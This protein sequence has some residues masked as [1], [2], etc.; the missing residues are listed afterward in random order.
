VEPASTAGTWAK[1]AEGVKDWPLWLF[2][3][4]ALSLSVF[5]AVPDFRG[6]VSPSTCTAVLFATTVAWILA[7]TRS[8]TP[9][10]LAWRTW[11][12]SSEARTR[13]VVTPI[14]HQC[15]WGVSKQTDGSYI[16]QVSGHF[17]VKNRADAPL[18]LMTATLIKPRIKG[19]VRTRL[20]TMRATNS[21]MHGTAYV[22]GNFIPPR[23]TLP[24]SATIL[25][26]GVP[27]QK[28]GAMAATIEIADADANKERVK[29]QIKCISAPLAA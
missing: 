20:L 27:K 7:A 17:M 6:L 15:V 16:T 24:V 13:F 5:L 19:E 11:R 3:S 8:V 29:L 14:E 23:G 10:V 4:V 22:S 2:V 25:I 9:A 28:V 26:C 12:A 21:R 1:I 18:H